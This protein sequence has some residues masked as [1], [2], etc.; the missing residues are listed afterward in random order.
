MVISNAMLDSGL[1]VDRPGNKNS[2]PAARSLAWAS[3]AIHLGASGT[4][5][6]RPAL[7]RLKDGTITGYIYDPKSA[8]LTSATKS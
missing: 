6:S 7:M 8:A 5:C 1:S 4:R 2:L 3:K